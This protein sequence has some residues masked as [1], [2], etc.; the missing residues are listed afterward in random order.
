MRHVLPTRRRLL[1]LACLVTACVTTACDRVAVLSRAAPASPRDRYVRALEDAGLA[2]T[3]LGRDWI[4]AGARAFGGPVGASVP[5]AEE[6]YFASG[7]ATAAAYR[8]VAAEGRRVQIRVEADADSGTRLFVDL[9]RVGRDSTEPARLV[10]ATDS[11][12]TS[13]AV[14]A[15]DGDVWVLRVQPE[16]LRAARYMVRVEAGPSLAFPVLGR[17]T[18]AVQSA[19][20]ADRDAGARRHEGID[21]FAPRGT[22]AVASAD[23]RVWVGDNRLGG[24]VVFLRDPVR[25]QSLYYAHLDTQLVRTGDAVQVGDTLGRVGNTG[26]ARTTAPHLHFGI[27]RPGRRAIDPFPFVDTRTATAPALDADA[28]WLGRLVRAR[29][30]TALRDSPS[31]AS[32]ATRSLAAESLAIVDGVAAGGWLRVRLPD[33]STGYVGVRSIERADGRLGTAAVAAG[34]VLRERPDSSAAT[35]LVATGARTASVFG[36]FAGFR[37][38]DVDGRRGW[39]ADTD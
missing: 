3:A 6:G 8:F 23:G 17:D 25:G 39:L 38:V 2:A 4:A 11:L 22:P 32:E 33:A 9:W 12:R 19:F 28:A 1:V 34:R 24:R 13:F 10:V 31:A 29:R 21:I 20:G 37:L 35:T 5:L 7:E 16:L 27:Y 26:N 18:R 14:E 15:D 36:R 30:A